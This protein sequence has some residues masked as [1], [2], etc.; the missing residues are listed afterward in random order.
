MK[1]HNMNTVPYIESLFMI[2][3]RCGISSL[4]CMLNWPL[5]YAQLL[6]V[7][8][9]LSYIIFKNVRD[10]DTCWFQHVLYRVHSMCQAKKGGGGT[11]CWVWHYYLNLVFQASCM[12]VNTEQKVLQKQTVR[13]RCG[14]LFCV[15]KGM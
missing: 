2:I 11:V 1:V 3:S 8:Q 13:M 12:I 4:H 10:E 5:A 14:S 9:L 7:I 15:C 6:Q